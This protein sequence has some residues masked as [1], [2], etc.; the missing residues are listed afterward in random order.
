MSR[1]LLSHLG[2]PT[3]KLRKNFVPKPFN[4]LL[5][6]QGTNWLVVTEYNSQTLAPSHALLLSNMLKAARAE[7]SDERIHTCWLPFQDAEFFID[8]FSPATILI[9]GQRVAQIILCTEKSV[10]EL[11]GKLHFLNSYQCPVVVSHSLGALEA[12]PETKRHT[13]KTI[14]LLHGKRTI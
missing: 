3:W 11:Q 2:I 12:Q 7:F 13:W 5:L 14:Q 6:N 10:E 4:I 1:S 8:N 9:L